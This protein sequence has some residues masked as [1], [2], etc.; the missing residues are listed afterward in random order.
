MGTE[1]QK[2]EKAWSV[3]GT[4]AFPGCWSVLSEAFASERQLGRAVPPRPCSGIELYP[5]GQRFHHKIGGKI[6]VWA[7][8]PFGGCI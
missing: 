5:K 8:F 2:R 6:G 3:L 1:A 7:N 4:L